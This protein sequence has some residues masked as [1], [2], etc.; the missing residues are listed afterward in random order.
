VIG[1][2]LL[3]LARMRSRPN[4]VLRSRIRVVGLEADTGRA[5]VS[6]NTKGEPGQ[7]RAVLSLRDTAF[8]LQ[9]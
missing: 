5:E 2:R 9:L 4:A 8:G 1:N 3:G 6:I 7:N